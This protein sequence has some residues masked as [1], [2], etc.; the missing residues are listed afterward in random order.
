MD[1]MIDLETMG[2]GPTPAII[3]IGAVLFDSMKGSGPILSPQPSF[4]RTIALQ[5][6]ILAG[7]SID[8]STIDWWLQQNKDAKHSVCQSTTTLESALQDFANF[9]EDSGTQRIW[10]H[11][12]ASDVPWLEASFRLLGMKTPWRHTDVRDTR[13]VFWMAEMTGWE[14]GEWAGVAHDALDDAMR[15]ASDVFS[16]LRHIDNMGLS[17]P[18]A[19]APLVDKSAADVANALAEAAAEKSPLLD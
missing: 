1:M 4:R 3:Q 2:L 8:M 10:S 11:G 6:S 14:R 7:A 17:Y 19:P 16:A 5:S 18:Q 15:Q 12:A 13:T 9:Y